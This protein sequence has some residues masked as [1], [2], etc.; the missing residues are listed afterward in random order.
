MKYDWFSS[1]CSKIK[2]LFSNHDYTNHDLKGGALK[3]GKLDKMS[4]LS[5]NKRVQVCSIQEKLVTFPV[6]SLLFT[7]H[8]FWDIAVQ[9]RKLRLIRKS[10]IVRLRQAETRKNAFKYYFV[11]FL[12]KQSACLSSPWLYISKLHSANVS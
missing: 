8:F 12:L 6:R 4:A 7:P 9:Y 2:H 10:C 11:A 5:W 1:Y 3:N